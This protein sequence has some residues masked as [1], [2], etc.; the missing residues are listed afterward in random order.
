MGHDDIDTDRTDI[1][2]ESS[3]GPEENDNL[4]SEDN[5]GGMPTALPSDGDDD[6][7]HSSDV[8]A[9]RD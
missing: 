3:P 4:G 5:K 6:G 7:R 8:E 9:E 2:T 1:S